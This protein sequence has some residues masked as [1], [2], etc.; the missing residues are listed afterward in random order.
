MRRWLGLLFLPIIAASP[1]QAQAIA[2]DLTRRAA[3]LVP[4][5]NGGGDAEAT[6]AAEFLR[7]VPETRLRQ[8]IAVASEQLGRANAIGTIEP[9]G[10]RRADLTIAY[11]GGTAHAL[12]AL[13][14]NGRVIG[15]VLDRIQ[16]ADIAALRSLDDVAG[17]FAVLPGAAGFIVADVE[18]GSEPSVALDADQPLGIASTFKLVVLAELVRQ[19]DAGERRWSDTIRRGKGDLPAGVFRDVAADTRI[20]LRALA[21][22]M[23]RASDNS[24]TDLLFMTLGRTRVEGMLA[25]LGLSY[26]DLNAPLLSTLELFKLK[27]IDAG[28]LGRRY[29][30]AAPLER[31]RLLARE[32]AQAPASTIDR[33]YA[34]GR[35]IMIEALEWFATPRDLVRTMGWFVR[36]R[37]TS[38]GREALRIL[39]LNPGPGQGVAG[40][41][42]YLGY[43]G[44]SEPGVV[45]MTVLVRD[46]AARWKVVSATWNNPA[47]PVDEARFEALLRRALEIVAG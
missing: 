38:G 13:A 20:S 27:G 11:E 24:A 40:R 16:P 32:V 34:Q 19:V 28:A 10:D 29:L 7:D 43:K 17:A 21:E 26:A 33:N 39:S 5:L 44:G 12:L 14:P 42:A 6:F 9:L 45:S 47:E 8:V 3:E 1:A 31:R 46:R 35:P 15:F 23:I 37:E 18:P 22:H 30:A 41:F 2:P 36:H 4:I 25:P